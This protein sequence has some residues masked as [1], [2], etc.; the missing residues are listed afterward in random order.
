MTEPVPAKPGEPCW[1]D[2]L[3]SD[4]DNAARFYGELFGWTAESAGPEY[5]GYINFSIDG[6]RVAGMMGRRPRWARCPTPGRSTSPRRR[7]GDPRRGRGERR[8]VMVAADGHPAHRRDGLVTDAGG[9]AVGVFQPT[10]T[11]LRLVLQRSARRAGSSCTPATSPR[12]SPGTSRRSAG[13]PT[14]RA[15]PTSSGTR[16]SAPATTSGPA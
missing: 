5:G 9:A 2:L 4:T 1:I 13:T 14:P 15:T 6:T 3:S 10:A 16:R 8:H 7:P 12:R 11:R